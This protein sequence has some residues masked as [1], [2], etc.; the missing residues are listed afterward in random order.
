MYGP[1]HS[2]D[3]FYDSGNS[4]WV[5]RFWLAPNRI[6][7]MALMEDVTTYHSE[8]GGGTITFP[9][10]VSTPPTKVFVWSKAGVHYY[11][12]YNDSTRKHMTQVHFNGLVDAI[13]RTRLAAGAV[14]WAGKDTHTS[15]P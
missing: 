4:R 12:N 5:V 6:T 7:G 11:N 14:G 8:L 1:Y 13:D 2:R 3:V 15:T 10:P 9:N